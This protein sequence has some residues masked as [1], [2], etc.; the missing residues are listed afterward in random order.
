MATLEFAPGRK[1][2]NQPPPE[3]ANDRLRPL[4]LH[5]GRVLEDHAGAHV[6]R[7]RTVPRH[8]G[9][10]PSMD[11][12]ASDEQIE[13]TVELPGIDEKDVEVTLANRVLTVRGEKKWQSRIAYKDRSHY[14]LERSYG[15]FRRAFRLPPDIDASQSSASFDRGVLKITVGKTRAATPAPRKIEVRGGA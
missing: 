4:Q 8:G 11:I 14:R 5:I 13:V 7:S 3:P 9:F 6:P 12:S 10:S 2:G 1:A 15:A